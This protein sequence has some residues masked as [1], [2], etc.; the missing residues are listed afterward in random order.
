MS[1]LEDRSASACD[2]KQVGEG[3]AATIAGLIVTD[4]SG[5]VTVLAV[6]AGT[7]IL[8]SVFFSAD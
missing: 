3:A 6:V 4:A 5:D 1:C 7:A 8:L 2:G